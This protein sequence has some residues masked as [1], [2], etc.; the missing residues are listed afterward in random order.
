[1]IPGSVR[2]YDNC[3][4]FGDEFGSHSF[5]VHFKGRKAEDYN[6]Y[7]RA[8]FDVKGFFNNKF[9]D[10]PSVI[11]RFSNLI[12]YAIQTIVSFNTQMPLPKL[13]VVVPDSDLLRTLPYD[14]DDLTKGYSRII[15]YIMTEHERNIAS[16]KDYL[17]ARCLKMDYPHILWVQ[18]P[19][20]DNFPDNQERFK[21]DRALEEVAKLHSHVS[22]LMLK[23]VWNPKISTLFLSNSSRFTAEGFKNYWE[24]VDRTVHYCDSIVLKKMDKKKTSSAK[25]DQKDRFKWQNPRYNGYRWDM[26][27]DKKLPTPPPKQFY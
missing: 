20:H 24:A 23:K 2:A 17:P 18:P 21:F 27:R 25:T 10:N 14:L 12:V 13:I 5:E 22:T 19:I 1:M 9:C 7:T 16:F 15:N 3:W 11:S 26:P 4:F 6:S 8:H